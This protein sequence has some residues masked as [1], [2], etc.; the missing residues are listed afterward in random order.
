MDGHLQ[1]LLILY[2]KVVKH[3]TLKSSVSKRYYAY[4]IAYMCLG[5]HKSAEP[6]IN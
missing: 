6:I 5:I 1:F 2:Y 4:V 3:I